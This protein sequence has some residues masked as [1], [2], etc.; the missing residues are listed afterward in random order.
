MES[1]RH[2]QVATELTTRRLTG[3]W[4]GFHCWNGGGL[5]GRSIQGE[6]KVRSEEANTEG[7]DRPLMKFASEVKDGI[8]G[9]TKFLSCEK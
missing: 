7:I 3:P 1:L 9:K 4:E 5:E 6:N 8:E 2:E